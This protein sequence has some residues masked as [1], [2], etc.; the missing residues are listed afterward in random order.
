[1]LSNPWES[2]AR[3]EDL[4]PACPTDLSAYKSIHYLKVLAEAC[5]PGL[6]LLNYFAHNFPIDP[7]HGSFIHA[8]G[9]L[10]KSSAAFTYSQ[11][12]MCESNTRNILTYKYMQCSM[13]SFY[14]NIL[15]D[16]WYHAHNMFVVLDQLEPFTMESVLVHCFTLLHTTVQLTIC[17]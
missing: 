6:H 5:R 1:M 8:C 15:Q 7:F 14:Y 12:L 9:L 10:L 4:E 13:Y 2:S 16:T 17:P 11:T 3:M